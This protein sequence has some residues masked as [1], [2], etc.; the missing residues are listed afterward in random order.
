MKIWTKSENHPNDQHPTFF[1]NKEIDP[2]WF[3]T[4]SWNGTYY[5]YRIGVRGTDESYILQG[6][7]WKNQQKAK[8][9]A[10]HSIKMKKLG[11]I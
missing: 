9:K 6:R 5:T 2:V 11:I 3:A 1:L 4:V 8:E 7:G 10:L